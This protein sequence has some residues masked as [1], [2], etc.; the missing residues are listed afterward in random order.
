[1]TGEFRRLFGV[2]LALLALLGLTVGTAFIDLGAWNAALNL[3]I[4]AIKATLVAIFFMHLGRA[5][6]LLRLA[7]GLPVAILAILFVLAHGDYASRDKLPAAWQQPPREA[8]A[9]R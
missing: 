1:M 2:W 5:P 4:A 8:N 7:A 6:A 3:S 9:D